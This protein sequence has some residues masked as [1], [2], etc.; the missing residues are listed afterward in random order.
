MLSGWPLTI[1]EVDKASGELVVI[2]VSPVG[3]VMK[4]FIPDMN[5]GWF[6]RYCLEDSDAIMMS[7]ES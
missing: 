2:V 1:I 3:T 4:T 5:M 6:N 7:M